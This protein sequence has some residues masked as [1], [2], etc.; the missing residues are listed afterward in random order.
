MATHPS[1]RICIGAMWDFLDYELQVVEVIIA[2][3]K[4]SERCLQEWEWQQWLPIQLYHLGRWRRF[5]EDGCISHATEGYYC[6]EVF[7]WP[8]IIIRNIQ[9][10]NYLNCGVFKVHIITY[11]L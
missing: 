10:P 2:M 7:F 1:P 8:N 11:E 5:L 3:H 4:P 9:L 6:R